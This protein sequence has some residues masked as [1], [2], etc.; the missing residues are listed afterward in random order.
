MGVAIIM[1]VGEMGPI[2]AGRGER[3]EHDVVGCFV[4]RKA[5]LNLLIN[6]DISY[7]T[8]TTWTT[9]EERESVYYYTLSYLY[10]S[11]LSGYTHK[12]PSCLLLDE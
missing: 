8:T 2:L 6:G 9:L 7:T 1:G 3:A 12:Q 10:F 11:F 4:I 5:L